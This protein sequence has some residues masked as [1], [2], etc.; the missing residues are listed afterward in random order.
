MGGRR[1]CW[2]YYASLRGSGVILKLEIFSDS[3]ALA[4]D[5]VVIREAG[6]II[7]R[8]KSCAC[9]LP[10]D[11]VSSQHARITYRNGS[12]LIEDL[13]RN[14]VCLNSPSNRLE[15]GEPYKLKSGDLILIDPFEIRVEIESDAQAVGPESVTGEVDPFKLLEI[16]PSKKRGTQPTLDDLRVGSAEKQILPSTRSGTRTCSAATHQRWTLYPP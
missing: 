16:E 13:S 15:K 6:G 3:G 10:D 11:Y 12:F 2:V 14:G 8:S 4:A 9:V 1:R 5:P 7:G